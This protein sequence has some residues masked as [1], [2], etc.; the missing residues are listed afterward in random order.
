MGAGFAGAENFFYIM[1]YDSEMVFPRIFT[2]TPLHVFT[3]IVASR[4][5]WLASH[6]GRHGYLPAALVSVVFLH[7]LYDYLIFTDTLGDGKF[8][9]VLAMTGSIARGVLR[10]QPTKM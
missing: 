3:A 7:G 10:Q 4:M 5:L 6:E 8:L 1:R 9:F 2:A